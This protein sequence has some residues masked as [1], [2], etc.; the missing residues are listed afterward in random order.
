MTILE[1]ALQNWGDSDVKCVLTVQAGGGAV[2]VPF[3]PL[4]NYRNLSIHLKQLVEN[5]VSQ[6]TKTREKRIRALAEEYRE[7]FNLELPL[8][9][10]RDF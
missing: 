3:E 1:Q 7:L 9:G 10:G 8:P 2:D 4:E 5:V 6:D